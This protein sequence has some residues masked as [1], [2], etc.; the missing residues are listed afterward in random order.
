MCVPGYNEMNLKLLPKIEVFY[1]SCSC[2]FFFRIY[3][4]G[5][6][7]L[8]YLYFKYIHTCFLSANLFSHGYMYAFFLNW[9]RYANRIAY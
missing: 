5:V 6:L 3:L 4:E 1:S 9:H 8:V 7:L 2:L